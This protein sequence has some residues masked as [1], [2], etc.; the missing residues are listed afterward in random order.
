MAG[1]STANV[2]KTGDNPFLKAVNAISTLAGWT[3]AAMIVAAVGITCQM[4]F[5]RF[6]LNQSTVW[7]TEAVIYL[8]IAATLIG[9]LGSVFHR[10]G[11]LVEAR[12]LY[13]EAIRLAPGQ[14]SECHINLGHLLRDSGD[15]Q[16]A[17]VSFLN[18][19]QLS[20]GNADDYNHL[21]CVQSR[22]HPPLPMLT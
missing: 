13:E 12:T 20:G 19:I 9:A 6:V 10:Q 18:G 1:Q 15:L 14:F 4:I 22:P 17:R 7:Q 16:S 2:A 21:A 5:V 8:V 3:S 11:R